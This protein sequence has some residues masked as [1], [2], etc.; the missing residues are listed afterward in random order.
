[1][2][3]VSITVTI[4]SCFAFITVYLMQQDNIFTSHVM[5]EKWLL[6]T[7]V[8]IIQTVK[9]ILFQSASLGTI[10]R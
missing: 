3:I 6:Y 10:S 4:T 1:M 8:L 2:I 5:H 7:N 9:T